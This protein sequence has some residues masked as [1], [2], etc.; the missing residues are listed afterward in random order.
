VLFDAL[1]V[2]D[3]CGPDLRPMILYFS[4]LKAWHFHDNS[5]LSISEK[6]TRSSSALGGL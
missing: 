1:W 5:Y 4:L 6:H 3:F 2:A